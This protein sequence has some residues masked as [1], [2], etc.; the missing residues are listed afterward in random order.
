MILSA[1]MFYDNSYLTSQFEIFMHF[2]N[3]YLIIFKF[4]KNFF[5]TNLKHKNSFHIKPSLI[6]SIDMKVAYI[7]GNKYSNLNITN[8]LMYC[9]NLTILHFIC[10]LKFFQLLD[11]YYLI[12]PL[13]LFFLFFYFRLKER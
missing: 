6:I 12:T 1:Y 2:L 7:V 13:Y 4:Y 3:K 10:F 5:I 8:L 9:I 11:S